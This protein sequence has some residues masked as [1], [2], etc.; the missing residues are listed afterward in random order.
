MEV[1]AMIAD[2][3]RLAELYTTAGEQRVHA[4][5]SVAQSATALRPPAGRFAARHVLANLQRVHGGLH[6]GG[7]DRLTVISSPVRKLD[8]A[9]SI[10]SNDRLAQLRL[11]H[12]IRSTRVDLPALQQQ[13][14]W[15]LPVR[16]RRAAHRAAGFLHAAAKARIFGSVLAERG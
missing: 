1:T 5:S 9:L 16:A 7:N 14:R 4:R 8:G 6:I 15:S 3:P 11:D 12:L 13:P 2:E 10:T